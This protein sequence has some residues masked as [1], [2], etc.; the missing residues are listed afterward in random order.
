M[1]DSSQMAVQAALSGG[2]IALVM[3]QFFPEEIKSGRLVQPFPLTIRAGRAH[4]FACPEQNASQVKV[5][6]FRDWLLAELENDPLRTASASVAAEDGNA[7]LAAT[8]PAAPMRSPPS[9]RPARKS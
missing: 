4:F 6:A 2:G 7:F 3:P 1:F 8:T 5:A 9:R